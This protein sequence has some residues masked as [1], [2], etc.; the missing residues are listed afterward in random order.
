MV[1]DPKG[2]R[3]VSEVAYEVGFK[4][5]SHFSRCFSRHFKVAPRDVR[6]TPVAPPQPAAS[7]RSPQPKSPAAR[8][9]PRNGYGSPYWEIDKQP[10]HETA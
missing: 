10:V 3:T 6:Q 2:R 1:A 8:V 9:A 4:N 7:A 5:V